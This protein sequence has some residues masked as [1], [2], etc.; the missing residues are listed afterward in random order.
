MTRKAAKKKKGSSFIKP[1]SI[2]ERALQFG[3][4]QLSELQK[5][6]RQAQRA[7]AANPEPQA[8]LGPSPED[9]AFRA[10]RF[11]RGVQQTARS[12][13]PRRIAE[14][15]SRRFHAALG[16]EPRQSVT[17]L[18]PHAPSV[19]ER[20]TYRPSERAPRAV[21]GQSS[22]AARAQRVS[23]SFYGDMINEH[24]RAMNALIEDTREAHHNAIA[25]R[26]ALIDAWKIWD[27]D[28]M[29]RLGVLT[30][31]QAEDLR[32]ARDASGG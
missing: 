12:I 2:A 20:P 9:L 21:S 19:H 32:A 7:R 8:A 31:Q 6:K 5:R 30:D 17:I 4:E 15:T 29:V 16:D 27:V 3:H 14:E 11:V 10:G 26:D 1:G 28:E 24:L 13:D 25:D 22:A 18:Q 23:M